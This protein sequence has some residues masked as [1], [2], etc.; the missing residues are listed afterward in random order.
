MATTTFS[1]DFAKEVIGILVIHFYEL[2]RVSKS[3][4]QI[5]L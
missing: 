4:K 5:S 1:L 2:G 3:S